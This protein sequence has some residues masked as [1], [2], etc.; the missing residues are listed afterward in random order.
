MEHITISHLA[1]MANITISHLATMVKHVKE[2]TAVTNLHSLKMNIIVNNFLTG[3]L[4][5]T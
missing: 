4:P 1:T 5:S 2:W 3:L